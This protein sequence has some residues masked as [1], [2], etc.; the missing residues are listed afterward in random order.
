MNKALFLDRDGVLDDLV[1]YA[2]SDSS[3]A[4]RY[5][6]DV[7][8]R[9][10][11]REALKRAGENGWLIFVVSNQPDAAKKKTTRAALDAVHQRLLQELAGAP[12]QE[13]FYCYHRSE[14]G[15]LCRK[16]KPF[17]VLEAAKKYDLDLAQSW[18][19]GDFDTDIECGQRA[20]CRTALV[21]YPQSESKRGALRADLIVRDLDH[22]VQTL[23]DPKSKHGTQSPD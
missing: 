15:C 2:D 1:Y 17:F 20:G 16:P 11:V 14:D 22:L 21:E 19:V 23:I 8:L 12:I 4:P 3:D 6:S 5:P 10:R 7:R 9:P 13:F 18:F